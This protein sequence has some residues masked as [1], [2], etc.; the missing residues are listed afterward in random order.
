MLDYVSESTMC[1][2]QVHVLLVK[3]AKVELLEGTQDLYNRHVRS[4]LGELK[5]SYVMWTQHSV[6]RHIFDTLLMEAGKTRIHQS[7]CRVERFFRS[8]QQV[9]CQWLYKQYVRSIP[10]STVQAGHR[11][12]SASL[13]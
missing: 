13:V 9:S 12:H 7:L 8:L 2:L 5:E 3:L 1:C 10:S 4:L 6:E 11:W